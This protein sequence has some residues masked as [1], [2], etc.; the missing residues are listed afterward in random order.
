MA[1]I[2]KEYL[3]KQKKSSKD[4]LMQTLI[5]GAAAVLIIIAF[6]LGG[7]FLG[8]VI[9]L[10]VLFGAGTLFIKFNREYEYILT[11]NELDIDVIYN[12]SKRK[13]VT[14]IDMKKIEAMVSIKDTNNQGKI[15]RFNKL[16]NASDNNDGADTYAI[17]S[18]QDNTLCKILITPNAS[19]LNELYKQAPHKVIKKI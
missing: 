14:T 19:F 18:S 5:M 10:I 7:A 6:L 13:R 3:I 2:F 9:I 4:V 16:I 1:E 11:N 15:E 12:K 17:I 8:P